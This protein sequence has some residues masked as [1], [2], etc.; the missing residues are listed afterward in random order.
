MESPIK[1]NPLGP[2]WRTGP[3]DTMPAEQYMRSIDVYPK[4]EPDGGG[5]GAAVSFTPPLYLVAVDT[6][7]IKTT[8][9]TVGGIVPT[10]VNSSVTVSSTNGTWYVFI[11]ATISTA[12]D[13][14]AAAI[15]SGTTV[16]PTDSSTHA[17][18]LVGTANVSANVITTVT[19]SLAWSQEFV[20]C[21]RDTTAS[22][23]TPGTYY[24]YVA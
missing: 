17:Y 6:A 11:D 21:G 1:Q 23:T 4:S 19:P 18:Y 12:G 9:G 22:T 16:V 8:Y 20:A 24:F 14:T 2:V 15:T 5:G 13:V 7:H 3:V 10:G